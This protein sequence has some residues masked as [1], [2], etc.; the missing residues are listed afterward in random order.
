[1]G[2]RL[3][4]IGGDAAGMSAASQAR[5]RYDDL[6]IV[7][8]EKGHWTS[9]SA[10][11]IPYLVGGEVDG[12][13][14]LIA[15]TPQQFRDKHRIDVRL[16]HE[17]MAIDLDSRQV[18]VRDHGHDRTF[19]LGFDQLMIGTGG[20]PIRPPL[21]GIDLGFVHGVQTLGDGEQLLAAAESGQC[22]HVVVVGGGYIG[23]EMAEAFVRWGADVTIIEQ[24]AHVMAT[25]DADMAEL[26]EAAIHR[27]DIDLMTNTM[28]T[29]FEPGRVLLEN[30]SLDADLVVLGIGVQPNSELAAAAGLTT[31]VRD[32]ISVDRRQRASA[33]GVYAAGDCCESFHLVTGAP[34]YVALGTVA[35]RQGRVAGINIGGGY[36]TF[37]GVVGTAVTKLCATEV[38]RTGLSERE[39]A[40][41]GF[42]FESTVIEGKTRAHYFPGTKPIV[43]K[44]VVETRT[45][46][47]LGG[48]IV[49]EEG[50]AKRI[51]VLAAA[52]TARMTA[53]EFV[54]LD[55]SYAPPFSPVWDPLAIAARQA[56]R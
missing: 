13:D 3:V 35:N 41:A 8:L 12:P 6:E 54:N 43:V 39:A 5:R 26:V 47:I 11:G 10:C 31:G 53:E 38:G 2:Q 9:Y 20:R 49:G 4:V 42:A 44:L 18:E 56:I 37:P 45:G 40:A 16:E 55:L 1:M 29:G 28:V 34:T 30:G 21:P 22:D 52:V 33:E 51:D 25:L 32:A 27:Y 14:R 23:L 46:R 50:A 24:A 36:A 15:R 48:Q 19:N 7:A 17:V